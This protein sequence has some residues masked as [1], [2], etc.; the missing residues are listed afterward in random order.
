MSAAGEAEIPIR[1]AWTVV[2]DH[3]ACGGLALWAGANRPGAWRL[4]S[5]FS[6]GRFSWL[7]GRFLVSRGVV[8]QLGERRVRIAKVGSSSLLRSI[9]FVGNASEWFVA[10]GQ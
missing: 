9:G 3:F 4:S 5:A 6:I 7:K 1:G 8:A 10:D 2:L